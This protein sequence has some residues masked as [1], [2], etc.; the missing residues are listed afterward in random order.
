MLGIGLFVLPLLFWL[1]IRSR[2]LVL[3]SLMHG[4]A[5]F[6]DDERLLSFI[7]IVKWAVVEK[8]SC[9]KLLMRYAKQFRGN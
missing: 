5:E 7:L 8:L 3:A 1:W 9:G 2:R 6:S 4:I